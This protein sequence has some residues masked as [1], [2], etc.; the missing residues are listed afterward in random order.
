MSQ[1]QVLTEV[2]RGKLSPETAARLLDAQ[3]IL[4]RNGVE[5]TRRGVLSGHAAGDC[6]KTAANRWFA[7]MSAVNAE[8]SVTEAELN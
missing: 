5:P 3:A 6:S 4:K 8:L 2:R 1:T 7:A